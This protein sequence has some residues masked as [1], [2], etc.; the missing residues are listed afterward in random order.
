MNFI[1]K[2]I[3]TKFYCIFCGVFHP[4]FFISFFLCFFCSIQTNKISSTANTGIKIQFFGAKQDA[5]RVQ[6]SI[7]KMVDRGRVGNVTLVP[8][9]LVFRDE[10][11][12]QIEV[13]IVDG[14]V[15]YGLYL[16]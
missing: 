5:S 16:L 12:L 6:E 8:S 7:Q 15:Y 4:L 13:C 11:V 9:S 2:N 14:I 3:Y 10:A 1:T